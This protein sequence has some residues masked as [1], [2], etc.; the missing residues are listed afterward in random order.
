MDFNTLFWHDRLT[1]QCALKCV[2]P[3]L[4]HIT[5]LPNILVA[6]LFKNNSVCLSSRMESTKT[7]ILFFF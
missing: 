2:Y 5:F 7:T 1:G 6:D 4:F 3:N